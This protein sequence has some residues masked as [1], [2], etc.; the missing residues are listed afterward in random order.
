[1]TSRLRSRVE[2]HDKRLFA[3]DF[4]SGVNGIAGPLAQAVD[5]MQVFF[6]YRL[7]GQTAVDERRCQDKVREGHRSRDEPW[8][9]AAAMCL[10]LRVS[11]RLMLLRRWL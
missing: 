7:E 2:L 6:G 8:C 5:Q 4:E 3:V 10:D 9:R 11:G 1:M